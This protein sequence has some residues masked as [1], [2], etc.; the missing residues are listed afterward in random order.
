MDLAELAIRQTVAGVD[1]RFQ[2]CGGY[3]QSYHLTLL[4]GEYIL[5]VL[6]F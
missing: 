3:G 4:A 2:P 1:G 5:K 6:Q